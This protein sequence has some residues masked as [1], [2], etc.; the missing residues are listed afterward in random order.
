MLEKSQ[1]KPV[2]LRARRSR[3]TLMDAMCNLIQDR[4]LAKISVGDLTK[5]AMVNRSTFYA[6]F[7][8][9]YDLFRKAIGDRMRR[10]IIPMF[11]TSLEF[12][13]ANL[14]TLIHVCASTMVGISENCQQVSM[15]ELVPVFMTE[16][17]EI[18]F[19]VTLSWAEKLTISKPEANTLAMFATGAI[20]GTS[21][22]WAQQPDGKQSADELA[23]QIMPLLV[24]G[25]RQHLT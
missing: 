21:L 8:D 15:G 23:D 11:D 9:K 5:E 1:T 18:I 4:P 10:G 12:T 22:L 17:Q 14:R 13:P 3:K 6:H 2:D 20:L 24:D 19:E 16:M 25:L 7:V